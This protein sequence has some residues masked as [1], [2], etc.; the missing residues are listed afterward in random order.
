[1]YNKVNMIGCPSTCD[2]LNKR[3]NKKIIEN[4]LKMRIGG[5][6]VCRQL[7]DKMID[8][9]V[10]PDD[11]RPFVHSLI[12]KGEYGVVLGMCNRSGKHFAVKIVNS[13]DNV[14]LEVEMQIKYNAIGLAPKIHQV[15]GYSGNSYITMDRISMTLD[16]YIR[17]DP[18][19]G[20]YLSEIFNDIDASIDL[21]FM[22]RISHGDMHTGNIAIE[23][24]DDGSYDKM[25]LIDFGFAKERTEDDDTLITI[26]LQKF[27]EYL[28]L[29]RSIDNGPHER[30]LVGL[31]MSRINSKELE[32]VRNIFTTGEDL[33]N[34][35]ET[36][37]ETFRLVS[38]FFVEDGILS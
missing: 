13:N 32:E 16:Y 26:Q 24:N 29:L 31:V 11:N 3:E 10:I 27:R 15:R 38:E 6:N 25:I 14:Q 34:N 7:T 23:L 30:Q 33:E 17:K 22:S 5:R 19:A 36:Q 37:D 9:G 12:G 2:L 28:Q 8:I 18:N 4:L 35:M 20:V 21:Q 1:M